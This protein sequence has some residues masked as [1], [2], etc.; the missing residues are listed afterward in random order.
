MRP[1]TRPSR[2]LLALLVGLL[3]FPAES[4]AQAR[5]VLANARL[6]YDIGGFRVAS[7]PTLGDAVE[8]FGPT[9]ARRPL[10]AGQACIA[11]WLGEGVKMTFLEAAPGP[12]SACDDD[13]GVVQVAVLS[14]TGRWRTAKG[15]LIGDRVSRLKLLYPSATRHGGGWWLISGYFE[16]PRRRIATL[17]AYVARE[18]VTGFRA[19]IGT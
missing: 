8:V 2:F 3:V 19:F 16:F 6:A 5:V 18:R 13:V 4:L 14:G 10:N 7:G 1:P 15:L 17:S 9:S 12:W 11:R